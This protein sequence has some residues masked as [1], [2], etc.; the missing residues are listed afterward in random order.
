MRSCSILR[1]PQKK[2]VSKCDQLRQKI[3]MKMTLDQLNTKQ[4]FSCRFTSYANCVMNLLSPYLQHYALSRP[5]ILIYTSWSQFSEPSSKI[6]KIKKK[7]KS[8]RIEWNE[9]S[10]NRTET[11][12]TYLYLK[13]V[14][15]T[16]SRNFCGGFLNCLPNL[17][18]G[19][20][21]AVPSTNFC[22]ANNSTLQWLEFG[23]S[24]F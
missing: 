23:F 10:A 4:N 15:L 6:Y 20:K 21:P 16:R 19:P 22:S 24:Y 11:E 18:I 12:L 1:Y 9:M 8:K 17:F 5:L 13:T 14:L 3:L 7:S 2:C